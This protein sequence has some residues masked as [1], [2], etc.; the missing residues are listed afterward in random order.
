VASEQVLIISADER[1]R[2]VLEVTVRL[3]GA[4]TISRH[5]VGDALHIPGLEGQHPTSIIVDIAAQTT[6][7]ELDDVRSLVE[8]NTLPIVVVLPELLVAERDRF[9]AVGATVLVRPYRPSELFRAL[10]PD[11]SVGLGADTGPDEP[12][13]VDEEPAE[14]PPA[15]D[16]PIATTPD[17]PI[18]TEEPASP[19]EG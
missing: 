15:P 5:S 18:A 12:L 13:T 10:W 8:A 6:A 7:S 16:E 3:G 1:W 4:E 11:K 9:V 2:R 14:E 19:V 17:E